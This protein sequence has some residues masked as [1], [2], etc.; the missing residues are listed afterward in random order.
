[1]KVIN[2]LTLC[3]VLLHFMPCAADGEKFDLNWGSTDAHSGLYINTTSIVNVVN[4]V[5]PQEVAV[6]VVETKGYADN[7]LRIKNKSI[8]IGPASI[9]EA[10]TAYF[11]KAEYTGNAINGLRALWG[12]YVTPIHIIAGKETG[13]ASIDQLNGMTMA[14]NPETT[15]GKRLQLFFDALEIKPAYKPYSISLSMDAM[16]SGA[17]KCWYKAGFKDDA[18]I[19]LEKIMDI[20]ILPLNRAMIDM[21]NAKYPGHGLSITIPNG[22]YKAVKQNQLSLAYVISDFVHK[23]V[24]ADVVYHIVKAVWGKRRQLSNALPTL[25]EGKFEDMYQ[26]AIDYGLSVPFHPG[27]VEFYQE[28]LNVTIPDSLLPPD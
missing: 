10:S 11:G 20:H 4:Q 19:E 9:L 12:G 1:M 18:I 28:K 6:T 23:D 24:P 17:A 8:H 25:K 14:M 13:I 27:A 2:G 5:R 22:L 3:L 26:M 7:L 15:S 21:M 16:K